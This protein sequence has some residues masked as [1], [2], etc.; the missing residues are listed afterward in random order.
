MELEKRCWPS[1]IAQNGNWFKL[2]K[3]IFKSFDEN[4]EK[5]WLALN[6]DPI[7]LSSAKV[8][9][10]AIIVPYGVLTFSCYED[11]DA[12]Q[13]KSL[14]GIYTSIV[15]KKIRDELENAAM[16][17]ART[18][19]SKALK[20]PYFHTNL[21][22]NGG[23]NVADLKNGVQT[24]D[25]FKGNE[26]LEKYF[27][28]LTNGDVDGIP[29]I[30][31]DMA[32]S[33]ISRLAPE[34]TVVKPEKLVIEKDEKDSN[35]NVEELTPITGKEVEYRTFLLDEDQVKYVNEMGTGHRVLLA[36]A[37]A[38]KSVL[39]LARAYRYAS[40]HKGER[41]L[42]TCFNNNLAEAYKFKNSCANFGDNKNVYIMTFHKLVKK[43][44]E[45]CLHTK[46]LG[47]F[48]PD[49]EIKDL[50]LYI[51]QGRVNL[52]F[53]AIFI[54][55]VQIF[56]PLFL[57][58]CYSLLGKNDDALFLMAG[59]L[60]QT[61]RNQSRRGDAPWKKMQKGRL[62][63]NGRVKYMSKNYRNC[64]LISKFLNELLVTMNKKLAEAN[65]I[66]LKEFD[67]DVFGVGP[68]QNVT[69]NVR[70]RINRMGICEK[71]IEAINQLTK[72]YHVPYSEIAILLPYQSV[73]QLNYFPQY[74]IKT[75]LE[76]KGIS[77]SIISGNSE[78]Q[79]TRYGDTSGIVL[80]SIDSAIGLDFKAVILA[81]L[82]P[83]SYYFSENKH[84][85]VKCGNWNQVSKLD[86][87]DKEKIKIQ[88]RKIYTACSRAREALYVLSDM[89]QGTA[90]DSI[91][92][93]V[94]L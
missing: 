2:E 67:Y 3:R 94:K 57:D 38:G 60:N 32:T 7:G 28:S 27:A 75:E 78:D 16:L 63:F 68:S 37:G 89:E 25:I 77:Y 14:M 13:V 62:N 34:Y 85:F 76:K 79:R 82:Y 5:G 36:N 92:E 48:P 50:Y 21:F 87:E 52:K 29:L 54:D 53:A 49:Q 88:I 39:L 24:E 15:E 45:E 31:T 81:G 46:L 74:W 6:I 91:L 23:M 71:V 20:F 26:Y 42:I 51:E 84:R 33:I 4:F 86:A 8:H 9:M 44:Y 66:D 40:A 73:K 30:D 1:S 69:V 56:D 70:T 65:M 83:Y 80:S 11:G 43:I 58:I 55:E 90:L 72:E 10:G 19:D 22:E 18:A 35:V 17:I 93:E 59:D 41:V 64:P 12:E 47:Q 61:V